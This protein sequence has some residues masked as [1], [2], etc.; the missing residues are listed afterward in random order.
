MEII[1]YICKHGNTYILNSN[2]VSMLLPCE[3]KVWN[4]LEL[5]LEDVVGTLAK[6]QLDLNGFKWHSIQRKWVYG[7]VARTMC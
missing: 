3:R 6:C 4:R 2:T 5:T 7:D 1:Y